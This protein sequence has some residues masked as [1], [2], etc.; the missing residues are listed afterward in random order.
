MSSELEDLLEKQIE[1]AGLP[2]P[3]KQH[4]VAP[5]RL[6]RMDFAWPDCGLAV[7]VQGLGRKGKG[8]WSMGRHQSP[9]GMANDCEKNYL[10]LIRGWRV[11]AVTGQQVRDGIAIEWIKE[12]L[13]L[14]GDER[15]FEPGSKWHVEPVE[16]AGAKRKPR[17]QRIPQPKRGGS[18]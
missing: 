6:H 10:A 3:I 13:R 16:P 4:R 14:M 18:K 17:V 5:P 7:E 1:S 2:T 12:L 9:K 15:P 8:S 11:L